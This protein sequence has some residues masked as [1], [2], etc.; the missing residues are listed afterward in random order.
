MQTSDPHIYAAGDCVETVNLITRRKELAPYGDLANLQGRVAGENAASENR[1]TFP[2]TIQTGICKVFDFSAG[3]AGLSESAAKNLG[4]SII[5][6][7][8]TGTD[9]PSYMDGELLITKLVVDK[10]TGRILGAQC[11]G[12]GN[13][14]KQV[15]Q[16]AMAIQGELDVDRIV[17]ADLPYAPP[18]SQAI[19][20]F[21][22]TA[23]IM[24]NKMKG[25]M[26][27]IS[28]VEVKE[29]T[30]RGETPFILD[31][32]GPDEYEAMRLGIGETLIPLGALRKRLNELPQDKNKEIVCYCKISLRAYEAALL[33]EANGWQNVKVMEGGIAAWP[34][35]REK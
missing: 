34:Y 10:A 12:P 13:A 1:A 7:V 19:D 2:G 30:N 9:K 24:Q 20:H 29:K 5:S 31:V 35:S 32:R 3:S 8:S 26:R 11:V 4:Y 33:L 23:H 17:N 28:S 25:R 16:W 27:G 15:A 14:G 6:V 21:I 18:F 22:T